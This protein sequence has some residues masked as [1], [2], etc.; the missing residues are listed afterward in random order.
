MIERKKKNTEEKAVLIGLIHKDQTEAQ[1]REYLEELAFLAET[2][3]AKTVKRYAQKLPHPDPRTFIGKGKLE[4]IKRYIE[5]K[6]IQV[7]IFDDE[8]SGS[9]ITNIEKIISFLEIR[10]IETLRTQAGGCFRS[11]RTLVVP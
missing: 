5:D 8:L 10:E 6:D 3:G 9:Q 1:V 2:A 7:A 4:E 11:A